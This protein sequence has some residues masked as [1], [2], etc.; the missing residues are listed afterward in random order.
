MTMLERLAQAIWLRHGQRMHQDGWIAVDDTV[1]AEYRSLARAALEAMQL[2][3]EEMLEAG[4]RAGGGF[5]G[6]AQTI[7]ATMISAAL[8]EKPE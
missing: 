2:P 6:H 4:V 3:S 8:N 7:W 1:K 5:N